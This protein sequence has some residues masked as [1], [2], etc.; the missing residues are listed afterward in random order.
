MKHCP[1]RICE[2]CQSPLATDNTGNCCGRCAHAHATGY[3]NAP[4]LPTEFWQSDALQAAFAQRHIG[5]VFKAYRETFNPLLTQ[6]TL[7]QW[8]GIS[9]GQ[10][11]RIERAT[12]AIHDLTK[13]E[14]WAKALHIPQSCLWF[15]YSDDACV[16]P[17]TSS[18]VVKQESTKDEGDDGMRRRKLIKTIALSAAPAAGLANVDQVPTPIPSRRRTVG[19]SDIEIMREMTHTFRKLDN[20]FGGGHSRSIVTG[21][22]TTEVE[23]ILRDAGRS[24][25]VNAS[26]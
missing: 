8:L 11:S 24:Q 5:L 7:A 19:V 13:L 22:L 14:E 25:S 20:R 6:T 17:D 9:Q 10:V 23:P 3:L 4:I 26:V 15:Q 2:K 21:Y 1:K 18:S 12:V 16:S